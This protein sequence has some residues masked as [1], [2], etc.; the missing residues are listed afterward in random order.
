MMASST[1][2]LLFHI[3]TLY[4]IRP[5]HHWSVFSHLLKLSCFKPEDS[6]S[7]VAGQMT[8]RSYQLRKRI[9]AIEMCKRKMIWLQ[10]GGLHQFP[11]C[12][13]TQNLSCHFWFVS[14]TFFNF[15]FLIIQDELCSR[16]AVMCLAMRQRIPFMFYQNS[17][18]NHC[19]STGKY[20]SFAAL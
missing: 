14:E 17:P 8:S 12:Q 13:P 4:W 16:A 9:P 6:C 11:L 3:I 2:S 5:H 19:H 7:P 18:C 10:T 20:F 1:V 15:N